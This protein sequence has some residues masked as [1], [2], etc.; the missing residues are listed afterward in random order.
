[1]ELLHRAGAERLPSLVGLKYQRMSM[2]AFIY[3][4]G[5][6]A[7]M[8]Y[9]LSLA[10]NSEVVTQLCGDAHVQNL[11][12][13]AGLDN[14]LTFDINDFDETVRG[15]FEWDIKR[16]AA[17]IL[18]AGHD[19]KL[20]KSSCIG[21]AESFLSAYCGL[22]QELS[23]MPVLE[24]ARYQ[25]RRL[26]G[27]AP[28]SKVLR[29]AER[30]TPVHARDRLMEQTKKGFQFRTEPPLLHRIMGEEREAVLA[31]LPE[32]ME[33]L[34][35]ECCHLFRQF[36]ARD[37]GFK[38]VGTGS[39]GLRDY[40]VYMEGNGSD[41]PL[42]LQIKQ[43]APSVYAPYLPD[44]AT[45]LPANQGQRVVEGQRAMQLQSDPLLGWTALHGQGYL[46]RQL[47]DHKAAIDT[48]ELN[49]AGL[50]EYGTVCGEMLARG[51]ARAG[52]AHMLAGYIGDGKQFI[53]AILAFAEGYAAQTMSDW[54]H[55]VLQLKRL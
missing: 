27:V 29:K 3:F 54:E 1:M 47:N 34:S 6:A 50:E 5:A 39:I 19:A 40:C 16:M 24:A 23:L 21:A 17:S 48:A 36:T 30:A 26:T 28:I 9:D 8:A 49:G 44:M 4:R 41:D 33:S 20:K 45:A 55:F 14:R 12:S 7:V 31:A 38:V 52:D 25:V 2:S 43:E 15:P 18:L 35:P 51:H 22:V 53:A 11:G 42:L 32:Y 13:Y 10:A 37:V 46:V